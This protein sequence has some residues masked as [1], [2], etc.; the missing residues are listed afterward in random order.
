MSASMLV[1]NHDKNNP[2]VNSVNNNA[3]PSS[4]E[5]EK[6]KP[7]VSLACIKCRSRHL[8]C[9][10]RG[11]PCGRCSTDGS[12]C[13]YVRSRRGYRGLRKQQSARSTNHDSL[14]GIAPDNNSSQESIDSPLN[15][16]STLPPLLTASTSSYPSFPTSALNEVLSIPALYQMGSSNDMNQADAFGFINL[17]SNLTQ[18]LPA[19]EGPKLPVAS[20][21]LDLYYLHFHQAHPI[22]LPKRM[23][24]TSIVQYPPYLKDM[25]EYAACHYTSACENEAFK[26]KACFVLS[27][28][29]PDSGFKV[30]ALLLLAIILHADNLRDQ[31]IQ[32]MD[33]AI[34]V[35]MRIGMNYARFAQE[36]GHG[37]PQL[38]ESWRR[39]WWEL[40][41][42]DGMLA[43]IHQKTSFRTSIVELD[44]LLPCEEKVYAE[45]NYIPEPQTVLQLRERAFDITMPKF[46]SFAY[47]IEA[48][49]ILADIIILGQDPYNN[50][51]NEVRLVDEALANWFLLLPP[52]K[53]EI[54]D[55]NGDIDEMLFQAHMIIHAS[56]INLHR[57]RS[58]LAF[59]P[60]RNG[61]YCARQQHPH[62][63]CL[64][65]YTHMAKAVWAA[66]SLTNLG[67]FQKPVWKHTPFLTCA[68]ALNAIV[69]LSSYSFRG[70][71]SEKNAIRQ[72]TML[73]IGV[74]K[75]LGEVW[76]VA[77]C[78][79]QQVQ[80]VAR[81]VL[82]A[83][84]QKFGQGN[85][86][87]VSFTSGIVEDDLWLSDLANSSS[88][89]GVSLHVDENAT[90]AG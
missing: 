43:S 79:M 44:V 34:D 78:V 33:A 17:P 40:Y 68:M 1:P 57:P 60:F 37:S 16:P 55:E 25:M 48:I 53:K 85:V 8:K 39:T 3:A 45:S 38:E 10:A 27:N 13:I 7:P 74:L 46:S 26:S 31:A 87:Q 2:T 6:E 20:Y 4:R 76:N 18:R 41:I 90:L 70:S 28:Q 62:I 29:V 81:E 15:L 88:E 11:P 42:I 50:N 83:R 75:T 82:A 54:I 19:M 66:N 72:R 84:A 30:Q 24:K 89:D 67:S 80:G 61:V 12:Q 69:Q 73:A 71:T 63:P 59:S 32:A 14:K 52:S 49:H 22:L 65:Q 47:R 64:E 56:S 35:A 58:S 5:K 21:L 86:D 9:D 77:H 23:L 51:D 36:C